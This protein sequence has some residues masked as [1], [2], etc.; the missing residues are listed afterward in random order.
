MKKLF[1]ALLCLFL[2]LPL[3]ALAGCHYP[4]PVE[5]VEPS[6]G[7]LNY[8]GPEIFG[9]RIPETPEEEREA[10]DD[11]DEEGEEVTEEPGYFSILEWLPFERDLWGRS[12]EEDEADAGE[13]G[14]EVDEWDDWEPYI[15]A[16]EEEPEPPEEPP[17]G[18]AL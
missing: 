1:P 17:A 10:E 5:E 4:E 6:R 7:E 9:D 8:Y 3:F 15:P 18:T 14:E 2:T 16:L 13:N 11:P 12:F